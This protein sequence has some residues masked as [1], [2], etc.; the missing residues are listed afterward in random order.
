MISAVTPSATLDA[1][2]VGA[3]IPVAN[4]YARAAE[5]AVEIGAEAIQVFAKSPRRWLGSPLDPERASVFVDARERL[6]VGPV[7]THTAYLIN[8]GARDSGLWDRSIAAYADEIARASL[9]QAQAVITHIG[10]RFE[11]DDTTASARRIAEA[12]CRALDASG[13][14]PAS[15]DLLLENTAG[16]GST[17]GGGF[18]ELGAVLGRLDDAGV[19]RGGLCLD[20]CHAWA[21]GIDVGTG[22]GWAAALDLIDGCCGPGRVRA[23]HANDCKFPRGQHKDRHEWIGDGTI[24]ETGFA[25]MLAEPRLQGIP[26]IVEMPGEIP[27]KDVENIARLKRLRGDA[28]A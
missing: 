26:A 10:T 4:G 3:H 16:A 13:V 19:P 18:D 9:L 14:D 17:F 1:M 5:Y 8:L 7:V 22:E 2:L 11:P 25:A 6:G 28:A 27:V 21:M 20:T 23:V 15:L 12:C 24:G